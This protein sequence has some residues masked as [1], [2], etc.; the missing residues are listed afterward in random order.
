MTK[1]SPPG[2]TYLRGSKTYSVSVLTR[3]SWPIRNPSRSDRRI[4]STLPPKMTRPPA[5]EKDT[6]KCG[7]RPPLIGVSCCLTNAGAFSWAGVGP[8]FLP[9]GSSNPSRTEARSEEHTSELQSQSNLV[10]RLLL[11][12]KKQT[13]LVLHCRKSKIAA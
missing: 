6:S 3:I 2:A 13:I 9:V 8:S 4:P 7:E 1:S 12:K 11:E 10:C 5:C